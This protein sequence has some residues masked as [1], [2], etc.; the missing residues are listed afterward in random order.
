MVTGLGGKWGMGRLLHTYGAWWVCIMLD[1]NDQAK[2]T[3]I[4]SAKS[5]SYFDFK[6]V[7][8]LFS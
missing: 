8:I 4:V 1:L 7:L 3:K 2:N 5:I 6:G